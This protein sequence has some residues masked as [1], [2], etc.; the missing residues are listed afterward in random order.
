M[1]CK[2]SRIAIGALVLASLAAACAAPPSRQAPGGAAASAPTA[3]SVKRMS[4]GLLSDPAAVWDTTGGRGI[5]P[6]IRLL[7]GLVSAGLTVKDEAGLIRPQLAE[8][9]PSVENGLWIVLPDGRMETTWRIRENVRWQDGVAFSADDLLF[10]AQVGDDRE[11]AAFRHLAYDLVD[12]VQA[13]DAR[14]VTVSWRRPYIGADKMFNLSSDGFA[15]PLPKHVLERSFAENKA[16]LLQHPYWSTEFVGIGAF[17]LREWVAGS[18]A[19]LDA[20]PDYALGRP[21]IDQIEAKFIPDPSTLLANVLAGSVDLTTDRSVSIEQGIT[22]RDQWRDGT[23]LVSI[24]GW[25]M[26]YPQLRAPTPAV[27]GDARFRRALI[28]AVDR[29]QLAETLMA[30]VVPVAHSLIP[31]DDAEY[32]AVEKSVVRLDYDPRRSMQIIEGLAFAR[33]GDGMFRDAGGQR[34]SVELRTTTNEANQKTTFAVGGFFQQAGVAP[35]PV[36]IPVQRLSDPEYRAT[37]PGLEL[38]SQTSGAE[39]VENLLH[40]KAA[41]LPERNHQAAGSNRNRGQYVSAEYDSLMDR[42]LTTI[43][44]QER[45][46]LLGLI[47]QQQTEQQLV[48]G[49]FYS[50]DAIMVANRLQNIPPRTAWN[51]H[52]WDVK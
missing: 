47:L 37:Y 29:Q 41:P 6:G 7:Q 32:P 12:S 31:P 18:R 13:A 50:A 24:T 52:L 36:V 51:G 34:L 5:V 15:W 28:H 17:K 2:R 14:T 16:G 27:L 22:L 26:M 45:L 49:L 19:I 20:F 48:M 23:M 43:P 25:T 30:G 38:V 46:Q 3:P 10:T 44:M 8:A 4:V 35:E 9:V 39:G 33:G 40:S 42:Y 21:K 11:V 1:N